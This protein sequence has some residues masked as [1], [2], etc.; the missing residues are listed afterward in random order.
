MGDPGAFVVNCAIK[1]CG[2]RN[3]LADLGASMNIMPFHV[4]KRVKRLKL[5][6]ISP[7][8]LMVQLADE[9]VRCPRGVVEDVLVKIDENY[10]PV[11]FV[12]LDVGDLDVPLILGRPFLETF[13]A[14]IDVSTCKLTLGINDEEPNEIGK[15]QKESVC[16]AKK[17]VKAK[18]KIKPWWEIKK[19]SWVPKCLKTN[20]FE[21][22]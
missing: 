14:L 4:I 21:G 6:Y 2:F 18:P 10:V 16:V 12:V 22:F 3:A 20:G 15:L 17:K 19:V 1:D 11:D 8:P 5:P 9:T 7:T 13:R